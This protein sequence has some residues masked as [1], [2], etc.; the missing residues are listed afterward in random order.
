MAE[1][2]RALGDYAPGGLT[3]YAEMTSIDDPEEDTDP[4]EM[5]RQLIGNHK[6]LVL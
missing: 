5:L 4:E 3:A 6:Q 2:I 1:R